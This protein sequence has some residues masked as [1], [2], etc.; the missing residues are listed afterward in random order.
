MRPDLIRALVGVKNSLEYL[1]LAIDETLQILKNWTKES[2]KIIVEHPEKIGNCLKLLPTKKLIEEIGPSCGVEFD[3]ELSSMTITVPEDL[4]EI[5]NEEI[6]KTIQK[7][8][9]LFKIL[10]YLEEHDYELEDLL[11]TYNG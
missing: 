2:D 11:G 7:G 1:E 4:N 9:K 10:W 8:I 6:L 5:F 3:P